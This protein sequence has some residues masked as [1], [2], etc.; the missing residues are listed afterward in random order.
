MIITDQK[1]DEDWEKYIA[2]RGIKV[3]YCTE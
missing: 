1:L 3:E 2:S